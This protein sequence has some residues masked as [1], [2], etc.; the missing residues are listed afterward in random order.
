MKRHFSIPN[1]ETVRIF[2]PFER[3]GNL[4]LQFA[5]QSSFLF[6]D[7]RYTHSLNANKNRS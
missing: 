5:N 6:Q 3:E 7:C 1:T 4:D 2:A